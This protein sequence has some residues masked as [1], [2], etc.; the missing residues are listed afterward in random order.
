MDCCLTVSDTGQVNSRLKFVFYYAWLYIGLSLKVKK[1]D[2]ILST[3]ANT[4]Y[5]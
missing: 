2:Y 3:P 1:P 5:T 4:Y